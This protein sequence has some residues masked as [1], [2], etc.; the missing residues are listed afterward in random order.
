MDLRIRRLGLVL[1]ACFVVLFL[2][3]NNIQIRQAAALDRNKLNDVGKPSPFFQPR[4][5]ILS[6]D[7]YRLAYSVPSADKYRYLRIYP[8][9]TA[10]MFSSCLLYTSSDTVRTTSSVSTCWVNK[11]LGDWIGD[12]CWTRYRS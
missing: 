5:E 7:G 6:A 12:S 4:G 11:S 8:K 3:L 9:R 1:V 2:Q 10:E